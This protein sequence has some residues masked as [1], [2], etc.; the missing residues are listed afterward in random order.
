M[1]ESGIQGFQPQAMSL[2]EKIIAMIVLTICFLT[3]W[4]MLDIVLLTFLLTFVFYYF[5]KF[6]KRL[7]SRTPLRNIPDGIFLI[8]VFLVGIMVISLCSI[9]FAPLLIEQTTEIARAFIRFDFDSVR[10]ALDPRFAELIG[11]LDIDSYISRL[12][13]L[14]LDT[15]M[16]VGRFGINLVLAIALSFLLLLE[17]K[18]I[19]RFG[20]VMSKSRI[21][22]I[23]YYLM[24]FGTNFC[25]SFGKVMKVQITIA[26]INASFSV[27][28][29]AVFHFPNIWGLGVMILLLGL[30]PVAG[31]VISLIPLSIIAF[32]SGGFVRVLEIVI[33]IVVMHV[34]EAYVLNPKLMAA[35][36]EL[37][38]S[39]VFI[40]LLVAQE[41]LKV[42]GLLIGV[43]LFVFMMAIFEVD[44]E[45]AFEEDKRLKKHHFRHWL[46]RR[47]SDAKAEEQK[48]DPAP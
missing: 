19:S 20:I 21:A 23:H 27:I 37:P 16:N 14:M 5:T 42:W 9:A 26:L 46:Q 1:T 39:F 47:N 11:G 31:V 35:R 43:P 15:L 4:F 25:R 7:F 6:V 48:K 29:L 22:F 18:K 34:I 28:V 2:K 38:V 36:M 30:I 12:G 17:K 32:N 8:F 44:Y 33:L 3:I 24:L 41:Y 40:I 13:M 45:S 10:K